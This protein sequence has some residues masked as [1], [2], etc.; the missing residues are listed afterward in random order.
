MEILIDLM[1]HEQKKYKAVNVKKKISSAVASPI[2]E[3]SVLCGLLNRV[4]HSL[5]KLLGSS[6]NWCLQL[7]VR[8]KSD[9]V[10]F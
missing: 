2:R 8:L 5:D 7:L 10:R 6:F 3:L 1:I 9:N 4:I